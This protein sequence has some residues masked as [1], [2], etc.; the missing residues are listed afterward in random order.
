M[1]RQTPQEAQKVPLGPAL[2]SP[3]QAIAGTHPQ[4][5]GNT[6]KVPRTVYQLLAKHRDF[7]RTLFPLE[8]TGHK[9]FPS[10][11][12]MCV[13]FGLRKLTYRENS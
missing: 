13:S 10:K 7:A 4:P 2:F 9:P 3:G 11:Y 1:D 6:H 5:P 12:G 8:S